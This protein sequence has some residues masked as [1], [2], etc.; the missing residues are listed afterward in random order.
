MLVSRTLLHSLF[1]L[2]IGSSGAVLFIYWGM[3]L[4]WVLG[5]M[6]ACASVALFGAKLQIAKSWRN[7]ALA[8]IGTL[9]G[10]SFDMQTVKALPGWS[11]TISLMFLMTVLYLLCSYQVLKRWSGM[12]KL[13]A[14]FSAVPGGL[15]IVT[16]LS[17]LYD[18][19]TRRI[20][21]S[22]SARLV[23]L[24][25]LTPI[26]LQYV[27]QYELPDRALLSTPSNAAMMKS[28]AWL[29]Y[30][31][32]FSCGAGGLLLARFIRFPTGVLLFP[33][34]FSALAHTSGLISVHVPAWVAALSQAII[35][36]SVGVRF[37]GYRWRDILQDG[38]ISIIIGILLALLSMLAA[39]A[40][41]YFSGMDF[42]P[43]LLVFL[44]GG[45]PELG[46][47]ALA[48]NINPAMV[49]THHMLRVVFLVG[50]VSF[51]LKRF[52]KPN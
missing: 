8:T 48:L 40:I 23:A 42:A 15:S 29:D 3:S 33:I 37:V 43:L 50:G 22:H 32:L 38:W 6:V 12:N 31:I 9:L 52:I 41:S 46:V 10:S 11:I 51:L 19:D 5:S 4:P 16:A 14:L 44:P 45:A 26:I 39:L 1:A 21:L 18:A 34:L 28:A 36:C 27:G 20:A 25:I 24:L 2:A 49:T 13:T 7:A 17:E 35:G 47:M 30:F